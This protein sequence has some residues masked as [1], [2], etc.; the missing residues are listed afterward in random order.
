MKKLF[1]FLF[2][3][4]FIGAQ[5]EEGMWI[6]SLLKSLNESDMQTMGMKICAEDIYSINKASLKDAIV[7]LNGGG[8][9]AEVISEKGLI[10][11]NHHCGFSQI[12]THSSL[13][14]DY[15]KNGFVAKSGAE[16]LI[17]ENMKASFIIMM[18]DVTSKVME[19]VI[20]PLDEA[21]IN[22]MKKNANE[23]IKKV[24]EGTHYEAVIKPFN[25]GNSYFLIVQETYT[26]I[27]LVFAPP[28]SIGKFGGDTD[29]W[30]WPRHTGDFCMFRIYANK[31]NEPA[32]YS[33]DNIPYKP[34][35]SLAISTSG[36][37]EGD[38]TMVFGFPGTTTE[39]LPSFAV[40]D[41]LEYTNP[42]KIKMREAS[43]S[44]IDAA[45][46]SS[47]TI[48]IQYA[49]KQARIS[50]AYKKWIGESKGL[51]RLN[52]VEKKK[53]IE[54]E[55]TMRVYQNEENIRKYGK[56]LDNL[57]AIYTRSK[58]Y[59]LAANYYFELVY[60]G[61]E[62]IRYTKSFEKLI[63]EYEELSKD[64]DAL[65]KE[66]EKLSNGAD[67]YFKNYTARVDKKIFEQLFPMYL[68]GTPTDLSSEGVAEV[69]KKYKNDLTKL[70]ND[71]YTKSIFTDL[72]RIKKFLGSVSSSSIK[73][74]RM[75]PAYTL[76]KGIY[77]GYEIKVQPEVLYSRFEQEKEMQIF[78]AGL[79]ETIPERKYWYDA[80]ST[81]R[82]GYG[83]VE[84]SRPRD[85]VEY[86]PFTTL[87]GMID[88]YI[89]GDA[90]FDLPAKI[91]DLYYKKD[92]GIYAENG[93]LPVAFTASNQT[94]GG[95]SGSPVLNAYGELIGLNF[96]RTWESTMSDIMYDPEQCRNIALDIRF[97]LFTVDKWGDAKY[98]VDEMNL[99]DDKKRV[100]LEK[101]KVQSQIVKLTDSIQANPENIQMLLRRSK[102]YA[103]QKLYPSAI[104][105]MERAN[106]LKP[107]DE[108]INL[109]L[110]EYN[111]RNNSFDNMVKPLNYLM[112]LKATPLNA[113]FYRAQL[114]LSQ[115][116]Y[117]EALKD[118]NRYIDS[119]G[120]N[121]EAY[122]IRAKIYL[123]KNDTNKACEDIS[124][125]E[126]LTGE[127][128][129]VWREEFCS[130]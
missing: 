90:E 86:I 56:T 39:Y 53:A 82:V 46:R 87:E 4:S 109:L 64:K 92:Y 84:G 29:N 19:G 104:K 96:D 94:T 89:P 76:M 43:L 12:Q 106:K 20:G 11:T 99:V 121:S 36:I 116:K 91:L 33:A 34:A 70:S 10:L 128:Q 68:E 48:R 13:E 9:T 77:N 52:A 24:T 110:C 22:T 103:Q 47:D 102:I 50:N 120:E 101:E 32:A 51:K 98:L 129:D 58:D 126:K 7:S 38:F 44:I 81:L 113:F 37:K 41:I 88:K 112:G 14:N 97:V 78:V 25:Y 63:D 114:K 23:I 27:R 59:T 1:I 15:L 75:D 30:M 130:Q 74:L 79:M 18:E 72:A 124:T 35:K 85:G 122:K 21:A 67:R 66:I 54:A 115:K 95:N 45:M 73:K 107:N 26:D 8:C 55:F 61:P 83:K 71:I 6:P 108:T 117:D 123:L 93:K 125:F 16:E 60:Y 118:M 2:S 127:P 28:S 57:K 3:F 40:E 119:K 17:C 111:W 5:A 49:A 100:L 80:N 62:F 31:E 65:A 69:M 105:D 42:A